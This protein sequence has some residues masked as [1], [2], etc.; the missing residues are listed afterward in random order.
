MEAIS[1]MFQVTQISC[2]QRKKKFNVRIMVNIGKSAIVGPFALTE[3]NCHKGVAS[4]KLLQ[5]KYNERN[6]TPTL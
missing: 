5:K 6:G 2:L 4:D 3:Q 1:F